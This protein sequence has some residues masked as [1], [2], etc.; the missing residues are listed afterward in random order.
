M[1]LT[2]K[3]QYPDLSELIGQTMAAVFYI[4]PTETVIFETVDRKQY[5]LYHAQDCCESVLLEELHGDLKDLVGS[6]ILQAELVENYP[7]PY[8]DRDYESRTWSF[9]KFA[10]NKGSVTM[11]WL[12]ESNGYYSESV[13]FMRTE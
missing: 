3:E 10:T 9:Y 2:H 5:K 6:P 12:G 8:P 1:G 7:E 4:K 13:D 11:R